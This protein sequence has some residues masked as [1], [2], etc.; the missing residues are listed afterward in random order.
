MWRILFLPLLHLLWVCC[1]F[2]AS[3]V[4]AQ[5]KVVILLSEYTR[6]HLEVLES[7]KTLL[8]RDAEVS[9]IGI[10]DALPNDA[11]LLV[12]VGLRATERVV[13]ANMNTPVLVTL[14]PR[15]SFEQLTKGG[16]ASSRFSALFMDVAP[17]RQLA[18]V[19]VLLPEAKRVAL[20]TGPVSHGDVVDYSAQA[21]ELGFSSAV[22]QVKDSSELYPA[23]QKVLPDA[24]LLLALP[25]PTVYNSR[26]IQDILLTT[27]R[28]RVPL[29]GLSAAYVKAGALGAVFATPLQMGRQAVD[30]ARQVL[31]GR[32]LPAPQY[33]KEF[34]VAV[35]AYV[36]RSLGLTI[37]DEAS[38]KERLRS[39]ER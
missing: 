30:I 14:L 7:F 13:R 24:D 11:T 3:I 23:L 28:A 10:D 25:D 15:S 21:K 18:F 33:P 38:L 20:L 34:D 19:R 9:S 27:Y 4:W 6:P 2:G 1:L 39:Q 5:G 22:G 35:N 16:R 26:T 32:P 37:L 17:R 29:I 31:A 8:D 36:A 12:T